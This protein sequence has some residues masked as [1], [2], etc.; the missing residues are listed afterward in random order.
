MIEEI[1]SDILMPLKAELETMEGLEVAGGQE[2]KGKARG[3]QEGQ[4]EEGG[5]G[6]KKSAT[7]RKLVVPGR[8]GR[9]GA[10]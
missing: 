5:K 10:A 2:E 4:K 9:G 7:P 1:N 3:G 6:G 8:G